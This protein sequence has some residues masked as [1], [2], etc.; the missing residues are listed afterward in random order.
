[1][2]Q[3]EG[4]LGFITNRMTWL[5]QRQ[6]ILAENVANADTPNFKAQDLSQPSFDSELKNAMLGPRITHAGHIRTGPDLGANVQLV[7]NK[8]AASSLSGNDVDLEAE[9]M[10]VTDTVMDYQTMT[11]LL[12]KWQGMLRTAI[13]RA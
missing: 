9:M 10:K 1:M 11:A 6:K 13:G 12:K 5:T 4:I 7:R 3:A 8:G 2:A